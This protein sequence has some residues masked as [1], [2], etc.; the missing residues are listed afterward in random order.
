MDQ[1]F[2]LLKQHRDALVW[3]SWLSAALFVVSLAIIPWLIARAPSNLFLRKPSRRRGPWSLLSKLV[4]NLFGVLLVVAGVLM[5][6]LPGQG[7]LTMLLGLALLDAPGKDALIE[8]VVQKPAIWR[9]LQHIRQRA[10]QPP[11]ERPQAAE[12]TDLSRRT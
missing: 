10:G 11:F 12:P 6:V 9:A 1:V 3:V 2:A 5:L 7:V 4:R 8:R